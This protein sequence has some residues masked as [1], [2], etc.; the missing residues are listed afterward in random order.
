MFS[1]SA[2]AAHQ[3]ST[4]G[5][6]DEYGHKYE[7]DS[8]R[9][10][11]DPPKGVPP[12]AEREKREGG[13]RLA[14]ELIQN[15]VRGNFG[16]FRTCYEAGLKRDPKLQG[17]VTVSFAIKPDGS[18]QGAKDDGST[19]PDADAVKCV[20]QGFGNLTYPPP[21][22]GYVTVVYPIEFSPGD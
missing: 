9:R 19:L 12:L 7:G 3:A 8:L 22:D 17:T 18:V 6:L 15:V 10:A 2:Q 16:R 11:S 21:Q 1:C 5:A 13:G 20:V 14:P 4:A